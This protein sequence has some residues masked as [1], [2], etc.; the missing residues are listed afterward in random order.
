MRA[1]ERAQKPAAQKTK[2]A[3]PQTKEPM[4]DGAAEPAFAETRPSLW[5]LRVEDVRAASLLAKATERT[6]LSAP[7]RV[8]MAGAPSA[9]VVPRFSTVPVR[10][11]VDAAGLSLG[12][13]P[14][15]SS[16]TLVAASRSARGWPS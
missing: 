13:F 11:R 2:P 8:P 7:V 12:I 9:L 1:V 10:A 3:A 6:G 16:E 4:D 5:E 14:C 15:T